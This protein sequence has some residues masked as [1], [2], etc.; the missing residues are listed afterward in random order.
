MLKS[1][2]QILKKYFRHLENKPILLKSSNTENVFTPIELNF[3]SMDY[4][5]FVEGGGYYDFSN[6][7]WSN[8]K[9]Q[10]LILLSASYKKAADKLIST[11]ISERDT[12]SLDLYFFP[13]CFLYRH[14]IEL[15]LKSLYFDFVWDKL[16]DS[17]KKIFGC[18]SIRTLWFKVEELYRAPDSGSSTQ[19]TNALES[20]LMEFEKMDPNGQ[21]FRYSFDKQWKLHFPNPKKYDLKNL[22]IR[23]NEIENFLDASISFF[24]DRRQ[25]SKACSTKSTYQCVP[26]EKIPGKD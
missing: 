26:Q 16:E 7:A 10:Q 19:Q 25:N 4:H 12:T 3:P 14:Y 18:H 1:L 5:L 6:V 24:M 13:A 15:S 17:A 11:A 2:A 20:Y 8:S 22:F 23:M 21:I 9:S